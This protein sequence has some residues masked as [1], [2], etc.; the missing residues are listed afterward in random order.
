MKTKLCLFSSAMLLLSWNVSGQTTF[1]RITTGAI[2]TDGGSSIGPAWGDY[3]NDGWI[4]LFVANRERRKNFLYHNNGD[5][6]FTKITAGQIVNEPANLSDSFGAAWGDYDNDGFLDLVVANCC[7]GAPVN[8]FLYRNDT[9]VGFDKVVTG[10]VVNDQA[11]SLTGAW[12]DYDRDGFIDLFV[13]AWGP[14]ASHV[15][16][17]YHNDGGSTFTRILTGPVANDLGAWSSGVW[18]DYDNDG[19]PDLFVANWPPNSDALYRNN[20]DGTFTKIIQGDIVNETALG[21]NA[22]WGDYDN[23]GYLDLFVVNEGHKNFLY[24]NNRNGSFTLITNG[25]VSDDVVRN[26]QSA[27]WADFDNDGYLDLF[28]ANGQAEPTVVGENNF[29]Y[30]NNGE[31]TFTKITSGH[32]VNDGAV[33]RSCAWGDYDNDGFLDLFVG[34]GGGPGSGDHFNFLYRNDTN[35]NHWINFKLVGRASNRSGIGA[36]VRLKA[37]IGGKTFWQLREI[38]GGGSLGQNDLRANFGLGD[39]TNAEVVR[40]EWP[41]GTVQELRNLAANQFLTVKEAPVLTALGR[42]GSKSGFV[43]ALKG[44][45]GISYTVE[46]STNLI[47][48]THL[49]S[50]VATNTLHLFSDAPLTLTT[51]S[52][53]RVFTSVGKRFGEDQVTLYRARED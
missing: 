34:N 52:G 40:I 44:G 28:V 18:G 31:G 8:D 26:S 4:D 53:K 47:Q 12:G 48:W 1:T 41:S 2:V 22:V 50:F 42:L 27:A 24:R 45:Q 13:S 7:L 43:M 23:D 25:I 38:S 46:C 14:G 33:S 11:N 19:W 20:R 39:A 36:K 15:N 17:L 5:S 6:T 3:D 37:T 16:F 30:R 35:S 49:T 29:L 9:G 51:P 32:L 10:P 21:N